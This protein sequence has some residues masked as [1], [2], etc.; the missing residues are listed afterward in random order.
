MAN[1][2]I[3]LHTTHIKAAVTITIMELEGFHY[4][5]WID[6]N[7]LSLLFVLTQSVYT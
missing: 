1:F 4:K 7:H 3:C 2:E 5:M 6:T